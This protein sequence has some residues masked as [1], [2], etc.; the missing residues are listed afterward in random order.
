MYHRYRLAHSYINKFVYH[1]EKFFQCAMN[2]KIYNFS[3]TTST[4]AST[5][6][7]L[8]AFMV[9]FHFFTIFDRN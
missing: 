5:D 9:K 7:K 8:A 4:G 2:G 1:G 6:T 3:N